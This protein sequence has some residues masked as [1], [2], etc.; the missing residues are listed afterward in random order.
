MPPAED[1]HG[2]AQGPQEAVADSSAGSVPD[3]PAADKTAVAGPAAD[4]SGQTKNLPQAAARRA[5]GLAA[6]GLG[7]A[8][9][10]A[11]RLRPGGAKSSQ[12]QPPPRSAAN[13]WAANHLGRRG[14]QTTGPP[15]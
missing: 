11:A 13:H 14:P 5:A 10:T 6:A 4:M 12:P 3:G 2:T 9:L 1:V 15:T 7:A 8:K